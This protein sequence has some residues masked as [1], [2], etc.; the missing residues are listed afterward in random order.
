MEDMSANMS[1]NHIKNFNIIISVLQTYIFSHKPIFIESLNDLYNS[2]EDTFIIEI[3]AIIIPR[4]IEVLKV[5]QFRNESYLSY[6]G[7]EIHGLS[8]KSYAFYKEQTM[9]NGEPQFT[10]CLE[11]DK[12]CK[13]ILLSSTFN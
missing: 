13:G 2:T 8:F 9:E 5:L 1:I 4:I 12:D 7:K 3:K 11:N 10:F 6:D